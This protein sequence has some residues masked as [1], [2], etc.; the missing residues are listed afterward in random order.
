M[1]KGK[2]KKE[3]RCLEF[4][5]TSESSPWQKL[6]YPWDLQQVGLCPLLEVFF[7]SNILTLFLSSHSLLK[8]TIILPIFKK[9]EVINLLTGLLNFV[10][11]FIAKWPPE[12]ECL[13]SS[14]F[15]LTCW[16]YKDSPVDTW[17]FTH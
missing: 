13:K 15:K 5:G 11:T 10:Y 4:T 6:E 2:R 17:R 14:S 16:T 9:I 3:M 1:W 7:V 12:A 8:V